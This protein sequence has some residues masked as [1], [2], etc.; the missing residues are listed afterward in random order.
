MT[1]IV[2]KPKRKLHQ[3]GYK[4][5][6]LQK[7]IKS[8]QPK[9]PSSWSFLRGT[10]RT[11]FSNK[12]FFILIVLTYAV[13]S[14]A[15]I[16][17]SSSIVDVVNLKET[18]RSILGQTG[19]LASNLALF[20]VLVGSGASSAGTAGMYQIIFWL[21]FSLALIYGL[22]QIFSNSKDKPSYKKAFYE[23][24]GPIIP[25]I[26]VLFVVGLQLLPL[27]IGSSLYSTVVS[28]GIAVT[29]LEKTLWLIML[30]SLC[31]LTLYMITSSI[32]ALY[33]VTLPDMTPMKALRSARE[34]VRYR[35][36]SVMRKVIALPIFLLL[37][38]ALVVIPLIAFVPSFAEITF[39]ILTLL[40]L[41]FVHTY[42]YSL[43]RELL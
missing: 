39:F 38:F 34:L 9:L 37:I 12:K 31:L 29:T 25:F 36:W 22:R 7:K 21:I 43:Y 20:G 14:Y 24:M 28:G 2:K 6:R 4:S 10:F 5:F 23:G 18:Y 26:L 15:F 13:C 11:I 16:R 27:S 3:P 1:D 42:I 8:P 40:I 19:G 32:F 17:S 35:R 33:I 41:P 30:L